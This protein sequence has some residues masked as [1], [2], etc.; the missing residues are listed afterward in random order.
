MVFKVFFRFGCLKGCFFRFFVFRMRGFS[1]YEVSVRI[2]LVDEVDE[3]KV[4]FLWLFRWLG[5]ERF[6]LFIVSLV[7]IKLDRCCFMI[8]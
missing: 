2:G 4:I 5:F 8:V 6:F 7:R 1:E 3:V